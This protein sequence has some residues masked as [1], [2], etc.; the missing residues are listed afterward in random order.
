[1]S[2]VVLDPVVVETLRQLTTPG[3][4]DVL[5][6]VLDLFL[7]E[8]PK[9]I[10]RV[11]SAWRSGNTDEV[12]RTAHSLKGSTGNIGARA[13]FAVCRDLDER[14]RAGELSSVPAL[15]ESLVAEYQRVEAEINRLLARTA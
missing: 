11:Q 3:E 8:T 15:I 6:Q 9:R 2:E 12:H 4:P 14:V 1:M 7:Q 13:M 10:E 5:A